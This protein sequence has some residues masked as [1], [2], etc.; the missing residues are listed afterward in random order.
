MK[1]APGG[2]HHHQAGR[3]AFTAACRAT[4]RT[5]PTAKSA[6][7]PAHANR[8][9]LTERGLKHV[10]ACVEAM[11]EVLGDEVGL[12][13]DC[14]PGWMVPDAI[15]LAQARGA[16]QPDV[17]GR[18]DHRRLHRRTSL[19]DVYREVT[20]ATSHA[21]PHRRA[22]LPAP[23]LQGADRAAGGQHRRARPGRRRR[24][25]RA[26][27]D[28]RVRRPA[29]HP[30]GAARHRRRAD[31]AGRAGAG[32]RHPAAELHRLRISGGAPVWWYD[33]VEGC[34]TR[35]SRTASSRS[36]TGP[37]W[38]S[39]SYPQGAAVSDGSRPGVL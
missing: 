22:D 15:R 33:I 37:A 35:S 29:R 8:G 4:C 11:K 14:G 17:A 36:G 6:P 34:R 1:A 24:H 7:A 9:L 38:G 23:E 16:A 25:R 19:A 12:A 30:D 31:R 28:R 27:V 39:S 13:L 20:H 18:P 2:L 5:S 3:S 32:V 21:D 10:I 26:E